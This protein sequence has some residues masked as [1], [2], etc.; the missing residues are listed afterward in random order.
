LLQMG[1]PFISPACPFKACYAEKKKMTRAPSYVGSEAPQSLD[2]LR[3][4]EAIWAANS[5]DP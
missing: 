3:D 4:F 2:C 5:D 1:W